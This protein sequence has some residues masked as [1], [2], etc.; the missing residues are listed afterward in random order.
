MLFAAIAGM[1]RVLS[2]LL[3]ATATALA[4]YWFRSQRQLQRP[5][6]VKRGD[7][8][9]RNAPLAGAGE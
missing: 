3:T 4:T 9:Y 8:I 1:T 2:I 6:R 5:V 7:L